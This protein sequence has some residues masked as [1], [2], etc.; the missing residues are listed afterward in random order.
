MCRVSNSYIKFACGMCGE[1]FDDKEEALNHCPDFEWEESGPRY[2]NKVTSCCYGEIGAGTRI[3]YPLGRNE[4]G[5]IEY[6]VPVCCECGEE[7]EE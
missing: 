2:V 1:D 3:E 6:E 7:L 5:H 4:P